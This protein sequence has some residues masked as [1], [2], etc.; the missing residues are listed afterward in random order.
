MRKLLL[1]ILILSAGAAGFGRLHRAAADAR[2]SCEQTHVEWTAGTQRV[3]ELETLAAGLQADVSGKKARLDQTSVQA[4]FSPDL[5]AALD[6]DL[7][8]R[9]PKKLPAELRERLGIAWSNSPDYILVAKSVLKQLGLRAVDQRGTLQAPVCTVLAI[10]ADERA[11]V[12]GAIQQAQTD[13]AAWTITNVLRIKPSGDVVAHYT[14]PANRD[15]ARTILEPLMEKVNAAIGPE[16]MALLR[17][18]AGGWFVGLGTLG[19]QNT[20]LIVR[21]Y[22]EGNRSRLACEFRSEPAEGDP[23]E[24]DRMMGVGEVIREP[25]PAA[26]R[27]VFPGGWRE[28]AERE[29]FALPDDFRDESRP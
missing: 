1:A 7:M 5:L 8:P 20:T 21:R 12:A 19:D 11:A 18:Y 28:L 29:G 2:N 6:R 13:H 24:G 17:D 15:Q 25:I 9:W 10:T 22:S 16:R 14:I 27:T 23:P 3:G 4:V 26:F